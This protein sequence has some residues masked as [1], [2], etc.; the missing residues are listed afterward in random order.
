MGE[1]AGGDDALYGRPISDWESADCELH[2]DED[3]KAGLMAF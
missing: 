2:G 3:S 1:G